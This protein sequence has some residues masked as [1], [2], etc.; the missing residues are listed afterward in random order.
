VVREKCDLILVKHEDL[1]VIVSNIKTLTKEI[2]MDLSDTRKEK[3][4]L[5]TFEKKMYAI[6]QGINLV[7]KR[8]TY[9]EKESSEAMNFFLR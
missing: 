7:E 3:V 2:D 5:R 4:D 9:D 6:E 1:E 8:L